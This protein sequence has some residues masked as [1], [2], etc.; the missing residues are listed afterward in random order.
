MPVPNPILVSVSCTPTAVTGGTGS[1]GT[2]YLVNPALAGGYVITLS[3]NNAAASVPASV[4]VPVGQT[5]ATFPITTIAVDAAVNATIS[6]S[7]IQASP[8]C[9]LIIN[10]AVVQSLTLNPTAVVG[11]SSSTGTVTLTG[12]A[13]PSGKV[14]SLSSNLPYATA[15]A[16]VTIAAN[17]SQA[18]ITV[19]TTPPMGSVTAIIRAF[20]GIVFANASLAISALGLDTIL[21][22]KDKPTTFASAGYSFLIKLVSPPTFANKDERWDIVTVFQTHAAGMQCGSLWFSTM[23]PS[24]FTYLGGQAHG[25]WS[26]VQSSKVGQPIG[27]CIYFA[28]P[29]DATSDQITSLLIPYFTAAALAVREQNLKIGVRGSGLVC[30]TLKSFGLVDM[31]W[32]ASD[33]TW[34]GSASYTDY[35]IKQGAFVI[36]SGVG[37]NSNV[38]GSGR[39][40]G[41]W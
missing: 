21:D 5:T 36:V 13:G 19:G 40:G 31:A 24:D 10:P 16:S 25:G 17:Q 14:V 38:L 7:D 26:T 41:L 32:L 15:P 18:T 12:P 33:M 28:V 4:T 11:G 1:T 35:D 37:C 22:T 30:S 29:F 9:S 6:A 2:V 3:S 27:S 23:A 39:S 20:T 8:T 34:Q